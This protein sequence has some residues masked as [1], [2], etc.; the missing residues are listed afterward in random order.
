MANSKDSVR[1]KVSKWQ[2]VKNMEG[3]MVVLLF[4]FKKQ[5]QTGNS[6]GEK[7]SKLQIVKTQ[8]G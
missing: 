3:K 7:V 5:W 4:P 6:V 1:A 2:T 8:C